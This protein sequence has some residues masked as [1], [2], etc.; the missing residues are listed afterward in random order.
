MMKMKKLPCSLCGEEKPAKPLDSEHPVFRLYI[1]ISKRLG[2]S[3][4]DGN[5]GVCEGCMEKYLKMRETYRK[6]TVTYFIAAIVLG[7]LYMYFTENILI[8]LLI[9]V[10]VMAITLL[11][12]VPPLKD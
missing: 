1:L 9:V 5:V 2:L 8:S 11:S 6:R 7:V 3:K 4:Y 10:V 12:Y